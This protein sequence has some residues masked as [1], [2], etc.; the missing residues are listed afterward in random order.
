[1]IKLSN[2]IDELGLTPH[3]FRVLIDVALVENMIGVHDLGCVGSAKRLKMNKKTFNNTVKS[4]E[5]KGLVKVERQK[6][7]SLKIRIASAKGKYFY[8]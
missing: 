7:L 4:L 6:G 8:V 3:E 1:M 5:G 2:E